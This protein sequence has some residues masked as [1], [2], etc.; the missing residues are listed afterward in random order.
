MSAS[1]GMVYGFRRDPMQFAESDASLEGARLR[2][3]VFGRPEP[4]DRELIDAKL[5]EMLTAQRADGSLGDTSKETGSGLL[6]LLEL[7]ADPERPEVRRAGDALLRQVRAGKNANEW[8]EKDGVLN[9]YALHA[10]CLLGMGEEPEV[11]HSLQSLLDRQELWNDPWQGCP[12]TPEVFWS[13]VWA[14]RHVVPEVA[15]AVSDGIRRVIEQMNAAGCCGYNDPWGFVQAAGQIDSPRAAALVGKQVPMILRGQ[16]PDGGW[17]G[18]SF[19]VFRALNAHGLLDE[20]R[21]LPPLPPDWRVTAE[22]PLPEGR[23]FSLAWD[24]QRFWSFERDSACAVALSPAD[25]RELSRVPI[26]NCNA[27]SCWDGALAAV[28]DKPKQLKKVDTATG[29]VIQTVPLDFME[30]PI[31]P[32]VVGDRVLVGEGFLCC[33]S[34]LDAADPQ[35]HREQTLAGP[36]PLCM[37]PD[38]GAVWHAD[39]WAPAIIKSDLQGT[40]LDWG[41]QPF[42]VRGLAWDGE[43]LWAL[44]GPKRRLCRLEKT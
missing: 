18:R 42:D 20:L 44:D 2:V 34:V 24:G 3:L 22:I 33:V 1:E 16:R 39:F 11:R 36:G 14:G 4:G 13:G 35:K 5:A 38:D 28:G 32:A 9:I 17:G 10:L 21:A 7:G 15:E 41:G 25:G 29:E 37:A 40:L 26:E 31:G 23:W 43:H 12:W 27:I 6:E 19:H 30:E 8:Y